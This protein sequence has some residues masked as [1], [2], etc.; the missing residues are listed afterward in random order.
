M[1][2]DTRNHRSPSVMNRLPRGHEDASLRR[3]LQTSVWEEASACGLCRG[4][5][6]A[7]RTEDAFQPCYG[8][9]EASWCALPSVV[10]S[11]KRRSGEQRSILRPPPA[12][13]AAIP[14]GLP[15]GEQCSILLAFRVRE[16]TLQVLWRDTLESLTT[17]SVLSRPPSLATVFGPRRQD[18]LLRW[19]SLDG[20][21]P[22]I[23]PARPSL[24]GSQEVVRRD[25][26][27]R[28]ALATHTAI[29]TQ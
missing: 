4:H 24:R 2:K 10:P 15:S 20:L 14:L 3:M 12:A 19:N 22:G 16:G 8:R 25:P 26:T 7:V 29:R 9:D 28:R 21:G 17:G 6:A 18:R 1:T 23:S 13:G 27:C 11:L 5:E